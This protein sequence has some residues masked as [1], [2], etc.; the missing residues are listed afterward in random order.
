MG[1]SITYLPHPIRQTVFDTKGFYIGYDDV[2]TGRFMKVIHY[3]F[4]KY[5]MRD[6]TGVE[7]EVRL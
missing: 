3:S 5:T 1:L 2:K 6:I 7:R 4:G